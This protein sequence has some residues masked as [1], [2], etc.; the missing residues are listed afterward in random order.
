MARNKTQ[1][2]ISNAAY[3]L[4]KKG[5]SVPKDYAKRITQAMVQRNRRRGEADITTA[6]RLIAGI[7]TYT[8]HPQSRQLA[9]VTLRGGEALH[10]MGEIG[11]RRQEYQRIASLKNQQGH[12]LVTDSFDEHGRYHGR[13]IHEPRDIS[14]YGIYK[15]DPDATAKSAISDLRR[16]AHTSIQERVRQHHERY[17]T[18]LKYA[19]YS[20][21]MV[22][23]KLK[24][25]FN[26]GLDKANV[27]TTT[28][29]GKDP[30]V[31]SI[32]VHAGHGGYDVELAIEGVIRA[33][34]IMGVKV[35]AQTVQDINDDL[36]QAGY[37]VLLEEDNGMLK[38]AGV[39]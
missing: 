2:A 4:R 24:A 33:I 12:G 19:A 28:I 38:L 20:T 35:D 11:K 32:F 25:L 10:L 37:N 13:T 23:T 1:R 31:E 16:L 6:R 7:S 27:R 3:E 22:S 34:Q 8:T 18:N 14:Q 36:M 21:G 9:P 29:M 17:V 30:L 39:I 26:A 15:G 5:F